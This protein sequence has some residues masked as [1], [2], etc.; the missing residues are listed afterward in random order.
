MGLSGLINE[1][2]LF[3]MQLTLGKCFP[4]NI[5]FYILKTDKTLKK[6][7]TPLP[8]S[9]SAPELLSPSV[10]ELPVW[11]VLSLWWMHAA[12]FVQPATENDTHQKN[13]L[14]QQFFLQC[15][16]KK[17][18]GNLFKLIVLM[19]YCMLSVLLSCVTQPALQFVNWVA[20]IREHWGANL[21][22]AS[23]IS[24]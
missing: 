23:R 4:S 15:V 14:A 5:W 18:K 1:L 10:T 9:L 3:L 6:A 13:C 19:T 20:A 22:A 16:Q 2:S 8:P 12:S 21:T 11:A 17:M 24:M 7:I